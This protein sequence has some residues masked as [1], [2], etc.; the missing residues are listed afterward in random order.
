MKTSE[1][2]DR[3]AAGERTMRVSRKRY[4]IETVRILRWRFISRTFYLNCEFPDGEQQTLR[5]KWFKP[6]NANQ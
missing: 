1:A 4:K 3:L 6:V 5:A 2:F